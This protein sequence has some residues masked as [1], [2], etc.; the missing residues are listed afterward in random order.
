MTLKIAKD[1]IKNINSNTI[2]DEDKEEAIEVMLNMQFENV[3]R[4]Y[5]VWQAFKWYWAR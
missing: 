1:I 2:S 3:P 4:K 5:E